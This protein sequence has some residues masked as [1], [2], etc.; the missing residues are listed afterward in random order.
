MEREWIV[1]IL[2]IRWFVRNIPIDVVWY[3]LCE[4]VPV[5]DGFLLSDNRIGRRTTGQSC[6][7]RQMRKIRLQ[8]FKAYER[9]FEFMEFFTSALQTA[10]GG[11]D[12]Q[13]WCEFNDSRRWDFVAERHQ[14]ESVAGCCID[15]R[16]DLVHALF[17]WPAELPRFRGNRLL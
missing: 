9:L 4:D 3:C 15:A 7:D 10:F 13:E 1:F 11:Q 6:R 2:V 12:E 14:R 16:I 5:A 17:R 8:A